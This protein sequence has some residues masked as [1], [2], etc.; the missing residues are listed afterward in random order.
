[1]CI[2]VQIQELELKV[3]E[4]EVEILALNGKLLGE[5]EE[6]GTSKGGG[7]SVFPAVIDHGNVSGGMAMMMKEGSEVTHW[8]M[9]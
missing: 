9:R 4:Q 7:A 6:S 3:K 1:M 8:T 2:F 5:R